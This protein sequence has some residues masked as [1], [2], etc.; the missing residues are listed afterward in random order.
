MQRVNEAAVSK[1][2]VAF[3]ASTQYKPN[4]MRKEICGDFVD[5]DTAAKECV[6]A[7]QSLE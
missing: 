3:P 5:E 4:I 1:E 7:H 6:P 2:N